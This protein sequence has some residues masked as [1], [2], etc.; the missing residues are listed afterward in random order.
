MTKK[1]LG[2]ARAGSGRRKLASKKET[3][4]TSVHPDA[5]KK[6]LRLATDT[7][8]SQAVILEHLIASCD[9]LP[10]TLKTFEKVLA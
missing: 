8:F 1:I 2:G 6:L 3:L 4:G 7:G 9:E 10:E 5:K